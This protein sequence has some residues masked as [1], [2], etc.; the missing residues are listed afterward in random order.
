[1]A[2]EVKM[3]PVHTVIESAPQSRLSQDGQGSHPRV[4]AICTLDLMAWKL[5]LPW[6]RG[7][8]EAGYE[9]HIACARANYFEQLA[10]DGFLMHDVPLRRR[11]NPFVHIVPLWALYRLIRRERFV[12]VN[13]HSPIAAAVGRVA[14]WLARA[15]VVI[16]TVH[17]F[18]FHDDMPRWKR[19]A[20][21]T[22]EWLLGRTTDRFMFVSDEDR[23]VALREGIARDAA[24]AMTIY[25]GGKKQR[26]CSCRRKRCLA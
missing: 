25:N 6:L 10:A 7:L 15:P 16:F 1:M 24:A 23:K 2:R 4:L 18:Y 13:A 5:L 19:R 14:A 3:K 11:M 12:V 22:L 9:V 17:G 21:I 26:R 8:R 20:Y